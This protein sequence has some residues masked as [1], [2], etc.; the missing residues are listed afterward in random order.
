MCVLGLGWAALPWWFWMVLRFVLFPKVWW[1]GSVGFLI[2]SVGFDC[3]WGWYN[4]TLFV[5]W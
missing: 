5:F 1:L 4:T 3:L 2:L